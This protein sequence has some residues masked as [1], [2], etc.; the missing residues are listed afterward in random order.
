MQYLTRLFNFWLRK[1][2]YYYDAIFLEEKYFDC[3]KT[4]VFPSQGINS[5]FV[6]K[7]TNQLPYNQLFYSNPALFPP[8]YS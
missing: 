3:L 5:S 2:K 6:Y 4:K 7:I 1:N 8:P